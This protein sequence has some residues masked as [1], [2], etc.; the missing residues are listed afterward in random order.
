MKIK[1]L[2]LVFLALF[3]SFAVQQ[4][5]V[6]TPKP[7]PTVSP[8]APEPPEPP[9]APKFD[10]EPPKMSVEKKLKLYFR[11]T[12]IKPAIILNNLH[13]GRLEERKEEVKIS[14]HKVIWF[15]SFNE[16][17]IKINDNLFSLKG[18]KTLNF[19]Q[20]KRT[21]N[22]DFANNW[23]Q[24]KLF[25]FGDRELIGISMF[26]DPCTGI[27]CRVQMYLIYDLETKTANFFGT[28][29][30]LLDREFGLFDFGNNGKLDF[31]SG[32]NEGKS[33]EIEDGFQNKYEIFTLNKD[34]VF[35]LLS[36]KKGEPYFMKRVYK[37]QSYEEVDEQFEYDWIEEIN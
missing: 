22:V 8:P 31:L 33:E 25:K 27:G 29:R 21:D 14:N 4:A 7:I 36:N 32:T 3:A 19:V 15:H 10:Y 24:I 17:K 9:E 28:Y 23:D 12:E 26:S 5:Q 20:D 16:A 13:I 6:N 35:Q 18:K 11:T 1:L 30:F 2:P 34:G 37:E